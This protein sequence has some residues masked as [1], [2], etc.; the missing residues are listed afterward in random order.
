MPKE[1]FIYVD[2]TETS[3]TK[4]TVSSYISSFHY[5]ENHDLDLLPFIDAINYTLRGYKNALFKSSSNA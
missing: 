3:N 4:I 5:T 2:F 1:I